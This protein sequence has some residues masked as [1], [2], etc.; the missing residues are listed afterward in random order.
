MKTYDYPK[1]PPLEI[2][3]VTISS[4]AAL[5]GAQTRIFL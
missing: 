5:D 3:L 4:I 2:S 1:R